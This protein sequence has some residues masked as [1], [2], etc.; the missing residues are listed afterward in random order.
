MQHY[1]FTLSNWII[2]TFDHGFKV[3]LI[4]D[5]FQGSEIDSRPMLIKTRDKKILLSRIS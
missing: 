4:S 1:E 3:T 5:T 2:P